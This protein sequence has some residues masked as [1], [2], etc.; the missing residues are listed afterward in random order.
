M[1]STLWVLQQSCWKL[2]YFRPTILFPHLGGKVRESPTFLHR[3]STRQ[4]YALIQYGKWSLWLTIFWMFR[5]RSRRCS[6]RHLD[7]LSCYQQRYLLTGLFYQA[8]FEEWKGHSSFQLPDQRLHRTCCKLNHIVRLG[9]RGWLEIVIIH[10]IE[11]IV[12]AS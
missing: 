4:W 2:N 3:I 5:R 1:L 11:E 10:H 6:F 12:R 9:S 8:W 7:I